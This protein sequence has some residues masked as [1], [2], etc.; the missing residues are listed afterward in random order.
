MM[1]TTVHPDD[2]LASLLAKS[3]RA[4]KLQKLK[5]L[6]IICANRHSDQHH[7]IS[8]FSLSSI[9]RE[10]KSK[11]LFKSERTLYTSGSGDYGTL[12][13]AWAAFSGPAS[14]KITKH[15][16]LVPPEHDYLTKIQDHAL[17]QIM[18]GVIAERD[19]LRQQLDILK[20]QTRFDVDQRP[21]EQSTNSAGLSA[22][23]LLEELHL[24]ESERTSLSRAISEVFFED[25][26]WREGDDGE[27]Y[28]ESSALLYDPGYLTSIRK[29]L[30]RR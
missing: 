1:R 15:H 12:I 10:C 27:V 24:T 9:G 30:G 3:P 18:Q 28:S 19:K 22:H 6:H 17:R 29:L 25:H 8:D 11:G 16:A 14:V 21:K 4:D 23:P 20:S 2:I 7:S 5:E 13:N 26:G